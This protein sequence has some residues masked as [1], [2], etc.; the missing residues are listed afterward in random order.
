MEDHV[1]ALI[2]SLSSREKSY[3]KR[4][5]RIHGDSP[6]RNY[7][8]IY[9]FL[10]KQRDYDESKLKER[11]RDKSFVKYLSS[12]KNYLFEQL[13][14]SLMN[15]HL[16]TTVRGK[17]ARSVLHVDI[18]MQRG[19]DG[20]ARKILQ[21]A[22]KLAYKYEEFTTIQ[23]LI[24]FEEE[25]IFKHGG[26][27]FID[28]L[29]ELEKE[30]ETC[31]EKVNNINKLR[32]LKAQARELQ[33]IEQYYVKDPG[34]YPH[35]FNNP[36]LDE[37]SGALSVIAKD[38]W[39]YI[40]EI[41]HYLLR[42]FD[43]SFR[44]LEKYLEFFEEHEY[45]FDVNKKLPLLSNYLYLAS[46]TVQT[47]KF[48]AALVK[49]ESLK[50]SKGADANYIDYIK[51]SRLLEMHYRGGDRGDIATLLPVVDAFYAQSG[52]SLGPTERDYI[53]ILLVR[54]YIYLGMFQKAQQ[55]INRWYEHDGVDVSLNLIKLLGMIVYFELGYHSLLES[56]CESAYKILRKRDRYGKLES[57]FI[58]F[59]KYAV[60]SSG[61][62]GFRDRFGKFHD[63]LVEIRK[64]PDQS[65]LFEYFD[66]TQWSSGK[67]ASP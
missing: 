20:K 15:Y 26:M 28:Q 14:N 18:L 27:N 60:R 17:L 31:I 41:R 53:I 62:S 3:F 40:R 29:D 57:E 19:F 58:R 39:F 44:W 59:F 36:M 35:I 63:T 65:M 46:K 9:E 13:L 11:F 32:L 12:E 16:N 33:F 54:S 45:L 1:H 30:R 38:F 22:K 7:L 25:I 61:S 51:Y 37:E 64:D 49:L 67:L 66:F 5:S 50:K 52:K 42:E 4:Y 48:R 21:H 34:K 23:I 6:D 43:E 24:R 8:H 56:E 47:G 2:H 10:E 55:W